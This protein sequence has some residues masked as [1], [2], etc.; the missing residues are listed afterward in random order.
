MRDGAT[1]RE[2]VA[3]EQLAED[4]A[5]VGAR[6]TCRCRRR[7]IEQAEDD[8]RGGSDVGQ[9]PHLV[10]GDEAAGG[11]AR[12]AGDEPGARR[13]G[14]RAVVAKVGGASVVGGDEDVSALTALVA[15]EDR[16]QAPENGVGVAERADV[17]RIVT[18]VRLLVGV[19]EAEVEDVGVLGLEVGRARRSRC[20]RRSVERRD[21]AAARAGSKGRRRRGT[22]PDRR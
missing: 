19:A 17:A 6:V 22:L 20:R 1:L 5:F 10:R 2:D 12:T 14:L 16:L 7:Q 15:F 13:L 8:A 4:G 9:S 3:R 18:G 11:D 21:R